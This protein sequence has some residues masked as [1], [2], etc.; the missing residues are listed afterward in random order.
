MTQL[1][2]NR[3][4]TSILPS[5]KKILGALSGVSIAK[6]QTRRRKSEMELALEYKAQGRVIKCKDKEDLFNQL[7]FITVR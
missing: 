1:I 3:E 6:P 7:G 5:L 2:L 4:D